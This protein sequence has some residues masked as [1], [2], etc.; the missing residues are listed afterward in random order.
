MKTHDFLSDANQARFWVTC[1]MISRITSSNGKRPFCTQEVARQPVEV[2][3]FKASTCREV[4]FV[5]HSGLPRIDWILVRLKFGFI[6]FIPLQ[7]VCYSPFATFLMII[8]DSSVVTEKISDSYFLALSILNC[9]ASC[10]CRK[11]QVCINIDQK[12]PKVGQ[13]ATN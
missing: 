1:K 6:I 11:L 7:L 12:Q 2:I 5:C 4:S 8:I 3:L 13:K 10:F 9:H